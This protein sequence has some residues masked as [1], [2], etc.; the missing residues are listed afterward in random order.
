MILRTKLAEGVQ[1]RILVDGQGSDPEGKSRAMYESLVK[2]GAVVVANDTIQLDYD[3][4]LFDRRFDWRQ[5]EFGHAEHRKLY[6]IDGVVAWTGGAGVK[7]NFNDGRF[8]DVMTRVTGDVV[9]Q[10]QAAF[11]TSFRAHGGPLPTDLGRYFPTQPDP[12]TLP[13]QLA[14]VV[15]G[16][17]VAA[18][19]ATGS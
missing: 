18:T 12:G 9:R 14:Q 4:P 8:H 6:V 11:L 1:V 13:V 16:G 19:Q 3:G 15:P 10:A 5:D 2:A 7:D 17:Y